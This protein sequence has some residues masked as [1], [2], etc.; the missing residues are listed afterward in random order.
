M[1]TVLYPKVYGTVM[2]V[3]YLFDDAMAEI[4]L[5]DGGRLGTNCRGVPIWLWVKRD[6]GGESIWLDL[7]DRRGKG[8]C[9]CRGFDFGLRTRVKL[10]KRLGDKRYRF[11]RIGR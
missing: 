7:R 5:D 8:H 6:D 2:G 11:S 9:G 1:K 4:H 3:M 10:F